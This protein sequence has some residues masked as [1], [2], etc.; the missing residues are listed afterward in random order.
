MRGDAV[1]LAETR[2]GGAVRVG[3]LRGAVR[4]GALALLVFATA[5]AACTVQLAPAYDRSLVDDIESAS[6]QAMELFASASGGTVAATF[7]AREPAYNKVI[8]AFD[9]LAIRAGAREVPDSS[10]L[11]KVNKELEKRGVTPLDGQIPSVPA[12]QLISKT[13][14]KMRDTDKAEGVKPLAVAAFKGQVVI[15]I[16]QVLTYEKFLE[17]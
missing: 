12:L 7:P 11:E 6:A 3:A 13:V 15:S 14:T 8:G 4:A 5:L 1:A 2:A 9:M 16:D 17:R 10:A